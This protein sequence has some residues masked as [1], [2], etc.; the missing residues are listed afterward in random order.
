MLCPSARHFIYPLLL[1]FT[2]V[3]QR[4]QMLYDKLLAPLGCSATCYPGS[5]MVHE[6][7]DP[8][9]RDNTYDVMRHEQT[10]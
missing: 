5:E 7:T 4:W 2:Q 10:L 3:G 1:H 9:T 6:P 8:M